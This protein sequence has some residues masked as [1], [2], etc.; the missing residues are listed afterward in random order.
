[1]TIKKTNTKKAEVLL[2]KNGYNFDRHSGN[3]HGIYKH[4]DFNCTVTVGY[5]FKSNKIQQSNIKTNV[6][7]NKYKL[8]EEFLYYIN[9][10]CT[11]TGNKVEVDTSKTNIKDFKIIK[12]VDGSYTGIKNKWYLICSKVSLKE[13]S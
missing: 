10:L 13:R 6:K 8:Y 7:K 11:I 5:K 1:M 3:A 2:K 4:E 12:D 9:Y